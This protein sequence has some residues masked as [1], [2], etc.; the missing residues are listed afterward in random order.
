MPLLSSNTGSTFLRLTEVQQPNTAATLSLSSSFFAFS[1]KTSV[2]FDS[3]S[4]TI[5]SICFLRTPPAL[6]I[7]SIA[8]SSTS[9]RDVSLMAIV[10][11]REWRMPTLMVGPLPPGPPPVP[12]LPP[13]PDSTNGATPAAAASVKLVW[14]DLRR[15]SRR[16]SL[17][18][19][20]L[21]VFFKL[22]P[23]ASCAP[24][25]VQWEN[26]SAVQNA[27]RRPDTASGYPIRRQH[28]ANRLLVM[29]YTLC[30]NYT[31][32]KALVSF[33]FGLP[34]CSAEVP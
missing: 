33:L 10:P 18:D 20:R 23:P 3:G 16:L 1:G 32:G 15:K 25:L 29:S 22:S 8:M 30:K 31:P 28:A 19:E 24:Q 34:R 4:S 17:D 7:S 11:V 14:P 21:V 9:L 27:N 12:P 13:Q 2:N 5:G 6:L 26:G